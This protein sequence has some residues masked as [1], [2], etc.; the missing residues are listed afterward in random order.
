MIADNGA[1]WLGELC[2]LLAFSGTILNSSDFIGTDYD[3]SDCIDAEIL[4]AAAS[5][6]EV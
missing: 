4:A 3:V 2:N 6:A 1:R 5:A